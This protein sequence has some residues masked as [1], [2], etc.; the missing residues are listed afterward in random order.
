AAARIAGATGCRLLCETFP[1]RLECGAGWPVLERVPY[2]PT[3]AQTFFGGFKEIVLAGA[4]APVAFFAEPGV[5]S[6]LVPESVTRHVVAAATH[7]VEAALEDLAEALA[8]P[9]PA[10]RPRAPTPALPREGALTVPSIV[11]TIAALQPEGLVFVDE[12]VSAGGAHLR[13]S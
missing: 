13:A 5:A 11:G 3:L 8:A 1:A 4:D 7:D 6:S 10:A 9:S 12:G 2:V